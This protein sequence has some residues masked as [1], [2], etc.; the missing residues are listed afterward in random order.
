VPLKSLSVLTA[1]GA[2]GFIAAIVSLYFPVFSLAACALLGAG[3]AVCFLN[4]Y[5]GLVIAKRYPSRFIMPVIIA[6][7]LIDVVI[8]SALLEV[9]RDNFQ[10]LYIIYLVVSV[11]M[12]I[13]CLMLEPYLIF[14]FRNRPTAVP[15]TETS[16][17]AKTSVQ[18]P[19]TNWRE[20]LQANAYEP[21][22]DGELDIAGLIMLGYKNDD[23][24]KTTRYTLNTVKTYRKNLYSK[25]EIHETRELFLRARKVVRE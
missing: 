14:S 1:L 9:F 5:C 3:L 15:T 21:L 4:G 12:T 18:E 11:A 22:I 17:S 20:M 16:A 25:L 23:I 24:S 10:I 19:E 13:L 6:I 2:L 8:H 7:A